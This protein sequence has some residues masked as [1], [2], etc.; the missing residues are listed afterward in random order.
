MVVL[1]EDKLLRGIEVPVWNPS[2]VVVGDFGDQNY[3]WR[4]DLGSLALGVSAAVIIYRDDTL[5][6]LSYSWGKG[7]DTVFGLAGEFFLSSGHYSSRLN[8]TGSVLLSEDLG[9]MIVTQNWKVVT[10]FELLR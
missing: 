8:L 4:E 10:I 9:R 6:I 3:E 1:G 7:G 5:H 2:A